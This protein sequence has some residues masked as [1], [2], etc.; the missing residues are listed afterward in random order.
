MEGEDESL[1]LMFVVLRADIVAEKGV[2]CFVDNVVVYFVLVL[3]EE[4]QFV[5]VHLV[6]LGWFRK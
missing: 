4:G 1:I 6:L 5:F 2:I 3:F